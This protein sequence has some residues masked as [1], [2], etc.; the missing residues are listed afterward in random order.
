MGPIW[1]LSNDCSVTGGGTIP[2]RSRLTFFP[3]KQIIIPLESQI[4]TVNDTC[5][6]FLAS[7]AFRWTLTT[8][9]VVKKGKGEREW[10]LENYGSCAYFPP[11]FIVVTRDLEETTSEI[12][13]DKC[14]TQTVPAVKGDTVYDR[15]EDG[16]WVPLAYQ[17]TKYKHF[18]GG[19]RRCANWEHNK[20][21]FSWERQSMLCGDGLCWCCCLRCMQY[22]SFSVSLRVAAER[23]W[24]G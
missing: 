15:R 24:L 17:M 6:P 10:T 5:R 8:M 20:S 16:F 19:S 18:C 7:L 21:Q 14:D 2:K 23:R 12:D 1:T 4:F 3:K 11:P 9:R 13:P 22:P